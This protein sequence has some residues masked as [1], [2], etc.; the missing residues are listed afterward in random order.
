M[1]LDFRL[2][3][4]AFQPQ[5]T[6]NLLPPSRKLKSSGE[7]SWVGGQQLLLVGCDVMP[8]SPLDAGST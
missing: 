2:G 1:E 3:L 8:T 7:S 5:G 4:T 6:S